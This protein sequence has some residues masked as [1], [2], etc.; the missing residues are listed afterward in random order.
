MKRG[1]KESK[2]G[3]ETTEDRWVGKDGKGGKVGREVDR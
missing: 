3:R 2:R 1:K